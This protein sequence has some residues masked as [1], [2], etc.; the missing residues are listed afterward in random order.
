MNINDLM[1]ICQGKTYNVNHSQCKAEFYNTL[2]Q[3]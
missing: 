2:L 1:F 3:L